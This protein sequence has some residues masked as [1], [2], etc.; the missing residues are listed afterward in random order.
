MQG[1]C[2]PP[3]CLLHICSTLEQF[4]GNLAVARRRCYVERRR[5][6]LVR[7]IDIGA[8]RQKKR[9][10]GRMFAV[11]HRG[12]VEGCLVED[13]APCIHA[14]LAAKDQVLGRLQQ[15]TL[16][17]VVQQAAALEVRAP[18]Q[19]GGQRKRLPVPARGQRHG[20]RPGSRREA[21]W[22]SCGGA[23][24]RR[25]ELPL[26]RVAPGRWQPCGDRANPQQYCANPSSDAATA[27]NLWADAVQLFLSGMPGI[28]RR[29][30]RQ[31]LHDCLAMPKLH[32]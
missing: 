29:E 18:T 3:I 15:V 2:R 8:V 23:G 22:S 13:A 1:R 30:C 26:P 6:V 4:P 32:L 20:S 17:R 10:E 19:G 25:R 12:R 7:C 27:P 16:H 31:T 28:L 5:E 24:P 14:N 21:P 9:C 11:L